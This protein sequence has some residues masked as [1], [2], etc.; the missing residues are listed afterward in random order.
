MSLVVEQRSSPALPLAARLPGPN[1][2]EG[3][4][5]AILPTLPHIFENPGVGGPRLQ[6]FGWTPG[7][8]GCPWLSFTKQHSLA[9]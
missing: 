4:G 9:Q 5:L 7:F 2:S 1:T 6:F 3:S 8:K